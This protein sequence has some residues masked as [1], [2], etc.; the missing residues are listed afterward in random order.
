[1]HE[2]DVAIIGAGAFGNTGARGRGK[3]PRLPEGANCP[4]FNVYMQPE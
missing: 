4:N 3:V 2:S 1:M